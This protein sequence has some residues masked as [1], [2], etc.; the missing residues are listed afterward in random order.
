MW[1]SSLHHDG[2][3]VGVSFPFNNMALWVKSYLLDY[4][5][6]M[7][8]KIELAF[9]LT[10]WHDEWKLMCV[11]FHKVV[12]HVT[13]PHCHQSHCAVL[14]IYL[15]LAF[16]LKSLHDEWNIMR[17]IFHSVVFYLTQPHCHQSQC[18]MM[19]IYLEL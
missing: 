10:T 4:Y 17:V 5:S 16:I 2:N 12:F 15:K 18:T 1:I 19:E 11:R 8:I 6:V 7:R 9:L 14:K 13:Q 3:L